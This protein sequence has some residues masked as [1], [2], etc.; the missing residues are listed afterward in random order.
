VLLLIDFLKSEYS[1]KKLLVSC[2]PEEG[3]PEPFYA[4]LGFI[5]TGEYDDDEKI[6]E[7]DI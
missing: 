2:V 6:M 1:A 5:P 7:L 3:G 4:K